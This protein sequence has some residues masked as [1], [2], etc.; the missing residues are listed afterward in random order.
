M[1]THAQRYILKG[2]DQKVK[3]LIA[4]FILVLG[5][6]GCAETGGAVIGTPASSSASEEG[7]IKLEL[8]RYSME[9]KGVRSLKTAV[10]ITNS[11]DEP[12]TSVTWNAVCTGKEGEPI[13]EILMFWRAHEAALKP[14]ESIENEGRYV[15]K[16]E[17]EPAAVTIALKE[18]RTE[19]EY[20]LDRIP[21]SG[22]YLYEALG[23]EKLAAIRETPPV[24]LECGVDQGGWLR[25]AEFRGDS[26][27]EALDLFTAI[28]IGRGDAEMV[29]DN[30]NYFLFEWED[31][32]TSMIRLNLYNLEVYANGRYYSYTLDHL[33]PFWNLI[34]ANVK[35]PNAPD[36]ER[37][38]DKQNE[39]TAELTDIVFTGGNAEI[40]GIVKNGSR[41]T[42]VSL[43]Y[44][45]IYTNPEHQPLVSQVITDETKL[46]AGQEHILQVP[47][48]E[49]VLPEDA[50]GVQIMI[51]N[52]VFE[53]ETEK[54]PLKEGDLLYQVFENGALTRLE[55]ELPVVIE[56]YVDRMGMGKTLIF[57]ENE[58]PE[59]V[60][61]FRKIRVGTD[62]MPL[63]T[64]SYNHMTFLFEDGQEIVLNFEGGALCDY[65]QGRMHRYS[66]TDT[67]AFSELL[68][69]KY[70]LH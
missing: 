6:L 12:V 2:G 26:L 61:A 21:V 14:G 60:E 23:D 46:S 8:L 51:H 18:V 41:K 65:A 5:L 29:T 54:E 30:Y 44:E 9:N 50:A 55:G 17:E 31:G 66:L 35:D 28:Q 37:P 70:R 24:R 64:D 49:G 53:E 4:A 36:P 34:M 63:I 11:S 16:E 69:R 33:E 22:E 58:I 19:A 7:G 68:S 43:T 59:A 32:T 45:V 15:Y 48:Y 3:K 56:F 38:M 27:Q 10:R 57:L 1:R 62:G 47:A 52:T 40:S 25:K 67:E 42:L 39:I 13:C 20:P